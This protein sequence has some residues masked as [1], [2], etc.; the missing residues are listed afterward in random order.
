MNNVK[1]SLAVFLLVLAFQVNAEV[2]GN[3]PKRLTPYNGSPPEV[4]L[5]E[6]EVDKLNSG[7]PVYKKI[8]MT[9][10][11]RAV[12]VFVVDASADQIWKTIRSFRDYPEW[13]DS[14]TAI[15]IYQQKDNITSVKF[16]ADH[17]FAGESTWYAKHN[18]PS[19]ESPRNWGTW[20]LDN[21]LVSDIEDSIG[22]W[23][24]IPVPDQVSKHYVFYSA[25]IRLKGKVPGFIESMVI[26]S[27]LKKAS[28][29]VKVQAE[30]L[31]TV[32]DQNELVE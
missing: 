13:I 28:Q 12:A 25:S 6:K 32:N 5:S 11:K 1:S 24:V 2:G 3:K 10:G 19:E 4:E 20:E 31:A 22:F 26:N 18:Y 7:R 14:V 23:R 17:F 9:D 15:E 21:E 29:W 16:T 8:T 30:L 27:G